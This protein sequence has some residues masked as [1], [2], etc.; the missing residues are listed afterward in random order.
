[1][2][3]C[4]DNLDASREKLDQLQTQ[5]AGASSKLDDQQEIL[6]VVK[7]EIELV[8][9]MLAVKETNGKES[10]LTEPAIFGNFTSALDIMLNLV[11]LVLSGTVIALV[12]ILAN[13]TPGMST[14]ARK[15]EIHVPSAEQSTYQPSADLGGPA[16]E[17]GG[18]LIS[19]ISPFAK[20]IDSGQQPLVPS[21]PAYESHICEK[22]PTAVRSTHIN[23]QRAH[24][25]DSHLPTKTAEHLEIGLNQQ[26]W[27]RT[28]LVLQRS[29][30][31]RRK[32]NRTLVVT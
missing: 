7:H 25:C 8:R 15:F 5:G 11:A 27:N 29:Q 12:N 19:C 30:L 16:N 23:N 1:M 17:V 20:P 21:A 22:S 6:E 3:S 14:I 4:K 26:P 2:A 32:G 31:P 18:V 24:S 13:R 10:A 9:E 28:V